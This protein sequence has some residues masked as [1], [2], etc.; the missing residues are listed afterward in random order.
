MEPG[1]PWPAGH[2][3]LEEDS[4]GRGEQVRLLMLAGGKQAPIVDDPSP[5]GGAPAGRFVTTVL[6]TDIVDSTGTVA[7]LGDRRWHALLAD[8]YGDCRAHLRLTGGELLRTTGDGIVAVFDGAARGVRAAL[9]I[10]AAARERGI[11][12]RAGVH[13]GECERTDDEIVGIA[14][15]IAA[16]ICALGD[17]DHVLTT[18]TVREVAMGSMLTFDPRG[19]HEL[20]GVPGGWMVFSAR[21]PIE[22]TG[23]TAIARSSNSALGHRPATC[24][25]T[26]RPSIGHVNSTGSRSPRVADRPK[27]ATT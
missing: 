25:R 1:H 23:R 13:T 27:V 4:G 11:A 24:G 22:D 9:A 5:K 16:R 3:D 14:I 2:H 17:A 18:G 15:H 8:H 12:V 26:V 10:Q 19:R 20:K 6:M 7:R 21:E